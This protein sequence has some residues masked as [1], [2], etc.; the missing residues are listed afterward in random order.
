M[1][2]RQNIMK[3]DERIAL[4]LRTLYAQHGYVCYKMSKFEEYDLYVRNKDFLISDGVITFTDTSG[5]LLALKPDVTLSIVK[6]TTDI[7]GCVQKVYYNENV[8]R[9]SKGTLDYK[10]LLQ[11]GLECIGDIDTFNICEVIELAIL[12]LEKISDRYVLDIAHMGVVSAV[13]DR[14]GFAGEQR[15][16]ALKLIESRNIHELVSLCADADDSDICLLRDIVNASGS[17]LEVISLLRHRDT[18]VDK[19]LDELEAI[20]SVLE[21]RGRLDSINIDFSVVNDMNYYNGIVFRGFVDKVPTGVLSGGQYDKLMRKFSR[22]SGA[23]GFA[24][25]IDVLER[26]LAQE[27]GNDVDVLL[28][29]NKGCDVVALSKAID[30]LAAQ[31]LTITAQSGIPDNLKYGT[32]LYFDGKELRENEADA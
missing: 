16:D 14:L 29:Y 27:R 7:S 22:T 9:V 13:L 30:T 15:A 5:K 19:A 25:Y 32:I 23:I 24:V 8:Y 3:Y 4:E 20:I 12:S 17:P 21:A 1:N 11:V 6:N 10:E 31:G 2:Q 26:L 18:A 28:V